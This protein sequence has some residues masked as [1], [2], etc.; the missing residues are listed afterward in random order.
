MKS[1]PKISILVP[2]RNDAAMIPNCLADI[3]NQSLTDYELVVVDDG[4]ND[5]TP[6]LLEKACQ[7]DSRIRMIRT[8]RREL[9]RHSTQDLLSAKDSTLPG[10]MPMTGC[11][12]QDWKNNWN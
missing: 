1:N 2:V 12:K 9:F 4:S 8:S 6:V 10:W 3:D 7:D 5:H 11:I